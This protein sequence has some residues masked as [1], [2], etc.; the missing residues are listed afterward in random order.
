MLCE[1]LLRFECLY[2]AKSPETYHGYVNTCAVVAMTKVYG[3]GYR[4]A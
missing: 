4:I 1:H 2:S 3:T